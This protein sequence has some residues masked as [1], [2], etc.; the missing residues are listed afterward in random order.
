MPKKTMADPMR[1]SANDYFKQ[2]IRYQRQFERQIEKSIDAYRA[3]TPA[4]YRSASKG[5]KPRAILA[6][7]DSWMRYAAGFSVIW[8]LEK[9]DK[10]NRICALASPGDELSE[11]VYGKQLKRLERELRRGPGRNRKYDVL[12]FSAGGNDLLG[13]GRFGN[14]LKPYVKG[15]TP[16]QVLDARI[17][18]KA[19]DLLDVGYSKLLQLRA[20]KSP[21]TKIYINSYDFAQ[22]GKGGV[23]GRGP[24][25]EPGLVDAGVPP[26]M[27]S[28]VAAEFL[29]LYRKRLKKLEKDNKRF[30]VMETQGV[31]EVNEWANEIHPTKNGFKKIARVFQ[32]KLE[33]DFP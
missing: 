1:K 22:P 29:K 14:Y 6:E 21:K 4:I 8:H 19:L 18:S 24:W 33:S 26:K 3:K 23:C 9:I 27:W 20:K 7:G 17:L 16:K 12:I 25:M 30:I 2:R 11:I 10:R 28:D 15:M 5:E 31:L 32:N 13:K